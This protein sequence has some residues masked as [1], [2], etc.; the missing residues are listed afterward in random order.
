MSHP[1]PES[2]APALRILIV[3]DHADTAESLALWLRRRGYETHVAADGARGLEAADALRPQAVLLDLGLPQF[4]GYEVAR[5]LR[6]RPDGDGLTLVA[7]S[8]RAL[9]EDEAR[10]RAAGFDHFLVKPVD[11]ERLQQALEDCAGR[12][13]HI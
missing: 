4:D 13:A 10:S 6:A 7:V 8:G 11:F 2:A 3:D 5:R 12:A 9:P 1:M